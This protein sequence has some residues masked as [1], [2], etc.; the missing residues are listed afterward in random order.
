MKLSITGFAPRDKG[1]IKIYARDYCRRQL[2]SHLGGEPR[3]DDIRAFFVRL[4]RY[5]RQSNCLDT[6]LNRI[7]VE[8]LAMEM[9]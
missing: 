3:L 5:I 6:A 9:L 2:N 4:R 8:F 1:D 7:D